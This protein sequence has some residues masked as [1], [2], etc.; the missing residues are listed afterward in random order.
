[1]EFASL[2]S[3]VEQMKAMVTKLRQSSQNLA[4]SVENTPR[5][6]DTLHILPRRTIMDEKTMDELKENRRRERELE[7]NTTLERVS[8]VLLEMETDAEKMETDRKRKSGQF[9]VEL[10]DRM[11]VVKRNTGEEEHQLELTK[12]HVEAAIAEIDSDIA[13]KQDEI[14]SILDSL[15]TI[16][17]ESWDVQVVEQ[18]IAA[19]EEKA[20][21]LQQEL[22][23]LVASLT[24]RK[25]AIASAKAMANRTQQDIEKD[26]QE[27]QAI[28]AEQ[29]RQQVER[30]RKHVSLLEAEIQKKSP[31]AVDELI[32]GLNQQYSSDLEN[33][34]I[35]RRKMEELALSEGPSRLHDC[36]L[37]LVSL[38][39]T[40]APSSRL[41][42]NMSK[43]VQRLTESYV[44]EGSTMN[45]LTIEQLQQEFGSS[46]ESRIQFQN[47]LSEL[48]SLGVTNQVDDSIQLQLQRT[49]VSA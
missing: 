5:I 1:M 16:E 6:L 47:A 43:T 29:A 42:G 17:T 7:F 37:R 39:R 11:D 30:L 21:R 9:R 31:S 36:S 18:R 35:K 49:P 4:T 44:A 32:Q 28:E 13:R 3:C 25:T 26:E 10:E 48:V 15:N 40:V 2:K 8:K 20:I 38:I 45:G 46:D 27:R 33:V 34:R 19:E 22:A 23:Q 41:G 12:Q 14:E 24:D